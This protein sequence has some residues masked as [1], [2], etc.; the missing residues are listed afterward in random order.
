MIDW[1]ERCLKY[2]TEIS[3]GLIGQ[4]DN[5]TSVSQLTENGASSAFLRRGKVATLKYNNLWDK[6][7]I[8]DI[9]KFLQKIS[10]NYSM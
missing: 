8:T 7:Q 1:C 10:I 6:T 5:R 4:L 3:R 9:D 2:F